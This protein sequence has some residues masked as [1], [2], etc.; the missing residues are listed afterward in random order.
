MFSA[1]T[2]EFAHLI[3]LASISERTAFWTSQL[4]SPYSTKL[5]HAC[6]VSRWLYPTMGVP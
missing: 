1:L 3:Q 5:S 4:V 2:P 6:M